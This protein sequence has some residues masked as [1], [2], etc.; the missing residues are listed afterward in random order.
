MDASFFFLGLVSFGPNGSYI[1][2]TLALCLCGVNNG[3]TYDHENK[4]KNKDRNLTKVHRI[5]VPL[6]LRSFFFDTVHLFRNSSI[7]FQ[8]FRLQL[9]LASD[10]FGIY[11]LH[12]ANKTDTQSFRTQRALGIGCFPALWGRGRGPAKVCSWSWETITGAGHQPE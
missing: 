4:K 1:L 2:L 9:L 5:S 11:Y 7:V 12:Q 6:L 3:T 8:T 10:S